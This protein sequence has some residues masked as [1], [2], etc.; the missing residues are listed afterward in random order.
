MTLLSS[1]KF[2]VEILWP[3]QNIRTLSWMPFRQNKPFY[4][5][6]FRP[7][8][9]NRTILRDFHHRVSV[10][11]NLLH[12]LLTVHVKSLNFVNWQSLHST[13][14]NTFKSFKWRITIILLFKHFSR[15]VNSLR[16]FV[17]R[18]LNF[19]PQNKQLFLKPHKRNV[20][21]LLCT[22]TWC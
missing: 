8:Q 5:P 7:V 16:L 2:L 20:Q 15:I 6:L 14:V 4:A 13:G 11:I 19:P 10:C 1:V 12:L 3:S 21:K 22:R 9:V 17:S 18:N